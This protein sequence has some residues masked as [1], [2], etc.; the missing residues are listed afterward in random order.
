MENRVWIALALLA[1]G[2]RAEASAGHRLLLAGS[3]YGEVAVYAADG[4]KEWS[5]PETQEVNDAW[6]L[7][8]GEIVMAYKTGVR[9]VRPDWASGSGCTV[10]RDRPTPAPGETHSCMPLPDGGF[11]IGESFDGVSYIV[12]LDAALNECRRIELKGLGGKHSTFRQ[13]RKTPAGTYLVTQQ[14]KAGIAMEI[15]ADGRIVRKF[16]DGRYSATRLANGNTLIACG[17]S[18]RLIEVDANDQIVW[19]VA[20]D[21][22][23]GIQIGFVAAALRLANGNTLFAN[24]GGHGNTT[25]PSL[26]EVTPDKRVAW[27]CSHGLPNRVSSVMVL[28]E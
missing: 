21:E 8:G 20:D 17:D 1:A 7:P 26:I 25:G 28:D 18:H 15:A 23:P 12:E 4:T 5:V 9:V 3:G 13:I 14:K 16:V 19:S 2:C 6:L 10:V 27:S 24:W 11:L 22:I